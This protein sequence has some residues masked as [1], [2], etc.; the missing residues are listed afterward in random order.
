MPSSWRCCFIWCR[1]ASLNKQQDPA[2]ALAELHVAQKDCLALSKTDAMCLTLGAQAMWVVARCGSNR[3][4]DRGRA[5]R[6]TDQGPA[7]NGEP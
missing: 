2:P 6:R 4:C 5:G 7:G 1:L 3:P